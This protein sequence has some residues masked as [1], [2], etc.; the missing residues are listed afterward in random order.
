MHCPYS[1]AIVIDG[2]AFGRL[3]YSGDCRPSSQFAAA[4]YG[5]DVIIHEATF[6]DGMKEEAVLKKHSTVGEAI[7]IACKMDAKTLILTHFSQRYPKIP[8]VNRNESDA[9]AMA[10]PVAFAFDFMRVTPTSLPLATMLTPALRLL[11]PGQEDDATEGNND[12]IV[13]PKELMAIP[14]MFSAQ[15]IL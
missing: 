11:Y 7:E 4:G 6:E 12:V 10:V 8:Q 9:K 3:A 15:G 2:T 1:Y 14:G 5:A 13:D